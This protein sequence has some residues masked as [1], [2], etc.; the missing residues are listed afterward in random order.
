MLRKLLDQ[1]EIK[2]RFGLAPSFHHV[3]LVDPKTTFTRP[4][5]KKFDTSQVIK[6]DTFVTWRDQF[7]EKKLSTFAAVGA[8]LNI[9]K[10]ETTKM[11]GELI[12]DAHR[13]TNPLEL[14]DFMRPKPAIAVPPIPEA[15]QPAPAPAPSQPPAVHQGPQYWCFKCK[16]GITA[17]VFD[18]CMSRRPRFGGRAYCMEHQQ[19]FQ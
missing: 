13:P 17:T 10:T 12:A 1:L 2:G 6:A 3:V 16:K 14:P 4:N 15:R 18:F 5:P 11:I 9:Q 19:D 7:V 8:L